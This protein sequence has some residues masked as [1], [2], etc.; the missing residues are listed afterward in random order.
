MQRN[1]LIGSEPA[2]MGVLNCSLDSFHAGQEELDPILRRAEAMVQAGVSILDVGG[3]ATNPGIQ[4]VE[5]SAEKAALQ[6]ERVLPVIEAIKSRFDTPMS[7]DTS[8]PLVMSEAAKAG[9]SCINDQRSLQLPGAAAV[10]IESGLPVV[11]MHS[12]L[13]TDPVRG[14][15][16]IVDRVRREWV[17]HLG[18]LTALGLKS[19]Q[20]ILDPGF[21]QGNYGKNLAENCELLA[22]L[23]QLVELGYPV[24]VGWSRKS[25]IGDIAGG[26]PATDRLPGSLVAAVIAAQKGAAILRVHD[27]AETVQALAVL[28]AVSGPTA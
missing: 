4:L 14:N 5:S 27:V 26:C 9:V 19:E 15:E 25:M 16:P 3:E 7:V 2:V 13:V 18:E 22:A 21:G 20:V 24:L 28:R 23:P 17:A 12:Y 1:N 8:E 6:C 11:L 10:A